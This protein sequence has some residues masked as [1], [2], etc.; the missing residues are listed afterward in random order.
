LWGTLV[1]GVPVL[2]GDDCLGTALTA[3]ATHFVVG[4][5]SA[6]DNRPRRRLFELGLSRDLSPLEIAHPW[7]SVSPRACIGPGVQRLAGSIVN[8]AAVLEANVLVNSGAIVEH[9]CWLGHSVHVSCGACLGGQVRVEPGAF[10]GLGATV[11]QGI[12]IGA[13]AVVGAGAVVV[14]DVPP[15]AVVVGVPARVLRQKEAA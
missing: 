7:S 1:Q 3:A 15:R 2:G 11:K 14:R 8:T 10:I 4:L 9:D 6:S 13:D 12:S 5:G